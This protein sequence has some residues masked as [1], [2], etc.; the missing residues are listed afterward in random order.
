M[1]VRKG[2]VKREEIITGRDFVLGEAAREEITG[3]LGKVGHRNER[4]KSSLYSCSL[5]PPPGHSVGVTETLTGTLV[6][7]D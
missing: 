1:R 3:D 6:Q 4:G 5:H 7:Q 2:R